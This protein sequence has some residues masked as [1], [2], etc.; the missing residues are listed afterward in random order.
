MARI[1]W[2]RLAWGGV[3]WP[4]F[5]KTGSRRGHLP[6]KSGKSQQLKLF[7]MIANSSWGYFTTIERKVKFATTAIWLQVERLKVAGWLG[8][9]CSQGSGQFEGVEETVWEMD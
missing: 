5:W 2:N 8:P 7:V 6:Q 3:E 9:G 1:G 4:R